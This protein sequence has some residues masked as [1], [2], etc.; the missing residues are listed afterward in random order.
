MLYIIVSLAMKTMDLTFKNMDKTNLS[1]REIIR[2]EQFRTPL[3]LEKALGLWVDRIGESI[4]SDKPAGFRVL[5]LY[6]VVY[7]KRGEGYY[8]SGGASVKRVKAGDVMIIYPERP[9]RYYPRGEWKTLWIVWGGSEAES[10]ERAGYLRRMI[11]RDKLESV[12][13]S[14]ISL[15]RLKA[16]EDIEAILERKEI[17]IHMILDLYRASKEN[18]VVSHNGAVMQK[19]LDRI[20]S[21]PCKDY[22]IAEL[23]SECCLS[24]T[25]FRRIFKNYSGSSPQEFIRSLKISKA[26][27]LLSAGKSIK[28]TAELVGFNDL[29]YFMRIFRKATG[30]TAGTFRRAT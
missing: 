18:T 2:S 12:N 16:R 1:G 25:H 20:N 28:E 19:L 6:A 30:I 17:L 29:F 7:I 26:K 4:S 13:K 27:Q 5:G 14:F 24:Q 11:V 22:S 9:T 21:N 23:A 15:F 8:E 3:G 10:L